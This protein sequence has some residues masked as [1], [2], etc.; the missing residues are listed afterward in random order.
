[1][2]GAAMNAVEAIARSHAQLLQDLHVLPYSSEDHA[3]ASWATCS[4][5]ADLDNLR[6]L[7][8][9]QE[10]EQVKRENDVRPQ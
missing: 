10:E 3:Y 5:Q 6:A 7:R 4:L 1:M 8:K 9:R 2:A